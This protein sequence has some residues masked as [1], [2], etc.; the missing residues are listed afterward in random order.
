MP[1]GLVHCLMVFRN[2]RRLIIEI[3]IYTSPELDE[4]GVDEWPPDYEP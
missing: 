2:V 1:P 3:V 4:R